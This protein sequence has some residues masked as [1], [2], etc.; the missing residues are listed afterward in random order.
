MY[1][2]NNHV[3][4]LMMKA[5]LVKAHRCG[6]PAV[7]P[8]FKTDETFLAPNLLIGS[9]PNFIQLSDEGVDLQRP[10]QLL[11]VAAQVHMEFAPPDVGKVAGWKENKMREIGRA[12]V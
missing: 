1:K 2:F 8:S 9:L 3:H 7:K 12:H 10:F 4:V 11:L 6:L 5:A